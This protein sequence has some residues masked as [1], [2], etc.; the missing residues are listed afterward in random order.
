MKS[1]SN[2]A[3]VDVG[4]SKV[5]LVV[6]KL[7]RGANATTHDMA[8]RC[9]VVEPVAEEGLGSSAGFPSEIAQAEAIRRARH[10]AESLLRTRL[11]K[12]FLL[13][14]EPSLELVP[15]SQEPPYRHRNPYDTRAPDGS[16]FDSTSTE[17]KGGKETIIVNA[18]ATDR[19]KR[20]L[21]FYAMDKR[22]WQ[23]YARLASYAG[24]S[25]VGFVFPAVALGQSLLVHRRA[26]TAETTRTRT[27]TKT[28]AERMGA[29]RMG[30]GI[31]AS[32]YGQ[33]FVVLDIGAHTTGVAVFVAGVPCACK[34]WKFGT[35]SLEAALSDKFSLTRARAAM[36]QR[37][38][39]FSDD[40]LNSLLDPSSRSGSP[41]LSARRFPRK[42]TFD[43]TRQPAS[44]GATTQAIKQ[45]GAARIAA[46][47]YGS[48][49]A[50]T[51]R[52]L[53]R[54]APQIG[55]KAPVYATGGG[56]LVA[57]S[58]VLA[59]HLLARYVLPYPCLGARIAA[60]R[61]STPPFGERIAASAALACLSV[62]SRGGL[63]DGSAP[64]TLSSLSPWSRRVKMFL[65][66]D[67]KRDS[68]PFQ[69]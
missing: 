5:A 32:V 3:L 63:D 59:S 49:F 58:H 31:E 55:D 20:P 43:K 14:N 68:L 4:A 52:F 64:P 22:R 62:L 44:L 66:R 11:R 8:A 13:A 27:K 30:T 10:R 47:A 35:A 65:S 46:A 39:V 34:S 56:S 7:S 26:L 57:G 45:Q 16:D 50:E 6:P 33:N 9:C 69:H 2:F 25:V 19:N 1:F 54:C 41:A 15:P 36:L 28:G 53:Q 18:V 51:A 12:V 23:F 42:D 38:L 37:S 40:L 29:E 21:S 24:L 67:D 60:G 48:L 61:S 17:G